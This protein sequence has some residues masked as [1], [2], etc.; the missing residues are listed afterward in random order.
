MVTHRGHPKTILFLLLPTRFVYDY[1]WWKLKTL[2]PRKG[3]DI[4][5]SLTGRHYKRAMRVYVYIYIYITLDTNNVYKNINLGRQTFNYIIIYNYKSLI[6][7]Y[8]RI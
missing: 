1:P 4:V 8:S 3:E 6:L 2:G 5:R 7:E